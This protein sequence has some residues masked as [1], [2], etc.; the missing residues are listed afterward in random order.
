MLSTTNNIWKTCHA[1]HT[2]KQNHTV[3]VYQ[4]ES[5]YKPINTNFF[6]RHNFWHPIIAKQFSIKK[7]IW[8]WH[9]WCLNYCLLSCYKERPISSRYQTLVGWGFTINALLGIITNPWCV[10]LHWVDV[11]LV[12]RS[13]AQIV[14]YTWV[15]IAVWHRG[16]NILLHHVLLPHHAVPFI[17]YFLILN[18]FGYSLVSVN[19]TEFNA[20]LNW[21]D[22]ETRLMSNWLQD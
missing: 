20:L 22:H 1:L 21:F 13:H 14:G 11:V 15:S 10:V 17:S 9:L 5:F 8:K 3:I 4:P 16:V 18:C 7:C 2:F 12:Y 6:K 19:F